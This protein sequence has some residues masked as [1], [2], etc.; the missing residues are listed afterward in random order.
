MGR[1]SGTSRYCQTDFNRF[2]NGALLLLLLLLSQEEIGR[3]WISSS[4]AVRNAMAMRE[5]TS[6]RDTF[7]CDRNSNTGDGSNGSTSPL[8]FSSVA[9]PLI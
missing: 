6:C 5:W 8:L 7:R 4:M 2:N 9:V 1:S 3:R